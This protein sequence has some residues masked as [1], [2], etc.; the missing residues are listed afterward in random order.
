V[1]LL[2]ILGLLDQ[3]LSLVPAGS[4]LWQKFSGQKTKFE[5]MVKDGRDPTDEEWTALDAE[6]KALEAQVDAGAAQG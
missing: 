1:P 3:L 4:A 5:Q 2:Y 6:V